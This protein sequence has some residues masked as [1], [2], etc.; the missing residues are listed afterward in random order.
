MKKHFTYPLEHI[1]AKLLPP[2]EWL[3]GDAYLAETE[4][5]SAILTVYEL[6]HDSSRKQG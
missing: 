4:T 5:R 6:G 2:L 3:A 1:R